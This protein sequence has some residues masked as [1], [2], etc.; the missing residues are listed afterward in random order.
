MPGGV[1][2]DGSLALPALTRRTTLLRGRL[3]GLFSFLLFGVKQLLVDRGL[4]NIWTVSL[5]HLSLT[6]V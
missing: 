3:G 2:V 4:M 6:L 1:G 5:D